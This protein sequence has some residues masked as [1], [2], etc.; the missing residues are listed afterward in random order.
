MLLHDG[1]ARRGYGLRCALQCGCRTCLYAEPSVPLI[2]DRR[3]RINCESGSSLVRVRQ[4]CCAQ[5][6]H[7]VGSCPCAIC[8]ITYHIAHS[9]GCCR[10]EPF[11]TVEVSANPVFF[12]QDRNCTDVSAIKRFA[13]ACAGAG[14]VG[15]C[16][17]GP[18]GLIR[19][20]EQSATITVVFLCP[21]R[22]EME[23]VYESVWNSFGISIVWCRVGDWVRKLFPLFKSTLP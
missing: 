12:N 17:S 10:T 11:V 2:E 4:A 3:R 21:D 9:S 13:I 5:G 22:I 20:C 6:I 1:A 16:P 15:C 14:A 18:K 23:M 19:L 8:A 7:P